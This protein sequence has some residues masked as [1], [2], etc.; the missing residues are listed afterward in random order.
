MSSSRPRRALVIAYSLPPL[1]AIGTM[2][3][4]RVV[5]QLAQRGWD[6]TILAG[7]PETYRPG[8]P[9]DLALLPRIPPGVRVVHAPAWRGLEALKSL[10]RGGTRSAL[11]PAAEKRDASAPGRQSRNRAR[12]LVDLVDAALSIPDQELAWLAPAVAKGLAATVGHRPDV[13]YSSAPPWTGQLV[14]WVLANVLR[15]PWVADFRD[16]W[17]RPPWREDRLAIT[18]KGA[19]ALERMVVQRAD[20]V[21]F[22]THANRDEFARH[23]GE[24]LATKFHVIP[25]GCDP[26]EFDCGPA[27][28][29]PER[30]FVLL[31]AGSLYAGRTP[32]SL[33]RAIARGVRSGVIAPTDFRLRFLGWVG[34]S[35]AELMDECRNLGIE[36]IVE[37]LPP[38]PRAESI[39]AMQSA[40]ALLLLQPGHAVSVPGK[41]YE[42]F[43]AGR[44][45]FAI[46]EGET[47][48]L[49]TQSGAGTCVQSDDEQVILAGLAHVIAS[50]Q[51][52]LPGTSRELYDGNLRAADTVTLLDSIVDG[53]RSR[54]R[55]LEARADA[56]RT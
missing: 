14:A 16:P 18:V 3:T 36:G 9:T 24:S 35:T 8:T 6:T 13:L 34:L 46:A 55:R 19:A 30:P 53:R 47:A 22:V 40:S 43:A 42:Y 37:F 10:A 31:H 20:R 49:V 44:P 45:I 11:S 32:A 25:N 15:C 27:P 50:A 48:A 5:Q 7:A 51:R 12:R 2:R 29:I 28:A 39:R 52:T 33:L 17:A 41:L 1:A 54:S 38:V 23:Y 56:Q 21:V 26:S 4:L